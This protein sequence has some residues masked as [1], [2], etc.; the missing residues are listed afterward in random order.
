MRSH[1]LKQ[2]SYAETIENLKAYQKLLINEVGNIFKFPNLSSNQFIALRKNIELGFV[3]S[4]LAD[5]E[6]Q[7]VFAYGRKHVYQNI[8]R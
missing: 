4:V 6:Y 3:S 8:F 1:I 2:S 7:A 5:W